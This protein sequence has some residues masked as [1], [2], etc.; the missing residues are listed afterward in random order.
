MDYKKR[1]KEIYPEKKNF[2]GLRDFYFMVKYICR[3]FQIQSSELDSQDKEKII[4]NGFLRNFSG[5][6]GSQLILEELYKNFKNN[7]YFKDTK[8]YI[9]SRQHIEA[10]LNDDQSNSR[11]LLIIADDI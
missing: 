6:D 4:I 2:H 3:C 7:M 8:F 5:L 9:N 10:N 1:L 11:H